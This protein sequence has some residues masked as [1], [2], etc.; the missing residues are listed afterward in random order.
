MASR[1][2]WVQIPPVSTI[3]QMLTVKSWQGGI[4]IDVHQ[5][6]ASS[7]AVNASA[8]DRNPSCKTLVQIQLCQ[9]N[10]HVGHK[11]QRSHGRFASCRSRFNSDMYPPIFHVDL[12]RELAS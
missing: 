12:C 6:L 7:I 1:M 10:F 4:S 11:C 5:I 2:S 3:K 8:R 9:P